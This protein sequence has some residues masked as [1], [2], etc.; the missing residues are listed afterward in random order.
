MKRELY[1]LEIEIMKRRHD[2]ESG[3][4]KNHWPI[5]LFAVLVLQ[6]LVLSPNS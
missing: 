2:F 1:R 6:L 4:T 5:T 3:K